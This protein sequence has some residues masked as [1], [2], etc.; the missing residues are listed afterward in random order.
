MFRGYDGDDEWA[1]SDSD[2]QKVDGYRTMAG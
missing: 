2:E 1:R